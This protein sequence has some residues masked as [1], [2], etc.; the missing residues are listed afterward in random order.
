M[1]LYHFFVIIKK[2]DDHMNY[3]LEIVD[4]PQQQ[5]ARVYHLYLSHDHYMKRHFHHNVELV[6]L[7]KGSFF[8]HVNGQTTLVLEDS[9]FLINTHQVHYFEM[10]EDSEMITV[11]LSYDVLEKYESQIDQIDFDLN[12]C[13]HQHTAL[14]E[15]IYTMD[16]YRKG[17]DSYKNI[18]VQEYLCLIYYLLLTYF[19]KPKISSTIPHLK[20]ME[21][22]LDYIENHYHEPITIDT[23]C[24]QLHYSPSYLCRYFK[25]ACGISLFQYIKAIRLNHA[26]IDVCQSQDDISLIAYRHGFVDTKAFIKAFK[27]KYHQTPG[28]YRKTLGQ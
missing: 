5:S 27:E 8:A 4:V 10:Q 1:V 13:P 7:I 6:Y 28:A 3:E 14:K 19:Q 15:A 9:L 23:L 12:L 11:L 16:R 17:N 2:G 18:K 20:Q 21:T 26:Y 22:L 24:Q 25:K